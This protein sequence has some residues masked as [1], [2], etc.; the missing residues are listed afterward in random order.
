MQTGS[1]TSSPS[2]I[3]IGLESSTT[4]PN[5]PIARRLVEQKIP[6]SGQLMAD[7]TILID[8]R[9]NNWT[10][11]ASPSPT[12]IKELFRQHPGNLIHINLLEQTDMIMSPEDWRCELRS[13][14][15][16]F[17]EELPRWRSVKFWAPYLPRECFIGR[18]YLKANSLEHV[19]LV[20]PP[21]FDLPAASHMISRC[22][23]NSSSLTAFE[24]L[25]KS[26]ESAGS[27]I[28][29]PRHYL[30]LDNIVA[31]QLR[32][33]LSIFECIEILHRGRNLSECLFGNVTAST[34]VL[35]PIRCHLLEKLELMVNVD[36]YKSSK[37][38][39]FGSLFEAIRA[40]KL[41]H[42][43]MSNHSNWDSDHYSFMTFLKRSKCTLEA[44]E[45]E[46]VKINGPQLHDILAMSPSL[47]ILKVHGDPSQNPQPFTHRIMWYLTRS[48]RNAYLLCPRLEMFSVNETV[49]KDLPD[50]TISK[51]LFD[52]I[53][54][55]DMKMVWLKFRRSVA[56]HRSADAATLTTEDSQKMW[57]VVID[58]STTSAREWAQMVHTVFH[59]VSL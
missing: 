2:T 36:D 43:K 46:N 49:V 58:D 57:K 37:E 5:R 9:W 7:G 18:M 31:L 4:L 45:L 34:G 20:G 38:V 26:R 8:I 11:T 33:K 21:S 56:L 35:I 29:N 51:M 28:I 12:Q 25:T 59:R 23:M 54:V 3:P 55:G 48:P 42:L 52:R 6:S 19:V 17:L 24:L 15:N 41:R 10:H 44:L 1:C 22:W 39:L 30:P 16:I 47:R 32:N 40:P 27:M 50:G 14:F 13:Y 53:L